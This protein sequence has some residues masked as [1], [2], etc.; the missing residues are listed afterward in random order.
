MD[1]LKNSAELPSRHQTILG[2][3]QRI[4]AVEAQ[5]LSHVEGARTAIER[6]VVGIRPRA[7]AGFKAARARAIVDRVRPRIR[8]LR[9]GSCG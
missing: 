4:N 9:T 6:E 5:R 2:E 7:A 8:H 1:L 3:R